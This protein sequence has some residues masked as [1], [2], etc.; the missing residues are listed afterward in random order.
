D[1]RESFFR[2]HIFLFDTQ[3]DMVQ[4]CI[5]NAEEYG[6]PKQIAENNIKKT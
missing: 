4:K 5:Y 2:G 6:I 3:K 1:K